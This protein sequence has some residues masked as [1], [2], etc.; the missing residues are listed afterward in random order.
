[1]PPGQ[2][3]ERDTKLSEAISLTKEVNLKS[4]VWW[5]IEKSRSNPT[6]VVCFCF[7]SLL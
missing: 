3:Y 1:M 5:N 6:R 4:L 7:V 2:G